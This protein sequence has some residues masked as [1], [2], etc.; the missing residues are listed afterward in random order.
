MFIE[1]LNDI[2]D[3]YKLGVDINVIALFEIRFGS[4]NLIDQSNINKMCEYNLIKIKHQNNNIMQNVILDD[5]DN[6]INNIYHP[7]I[8]FEHL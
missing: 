4:I 6:T 8:H 1:F 5:Y 2:N 7:Y 3:L